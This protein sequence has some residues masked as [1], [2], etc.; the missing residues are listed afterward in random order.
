[1][2]KK[3]MIL[4]R[5]RPSSFEAGKW[6][7]KTQEFEV[8]VLSIVDGW[9]MVRRPRCAPFVEQAKNLHET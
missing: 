2:E 9:A 8:T 7:Y 5:A 4:K 3:K 6:I 1:M